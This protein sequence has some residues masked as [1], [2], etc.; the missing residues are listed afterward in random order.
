MDQNLDAQAET[1]MN[2]ESTNSKGRLYI[3]AFIVVFILCDV[4]LK[5]MAIIG[6]TL[7]TKAIIRSGIILVT[8]YFLWRGSRIAYW[9]MILSLLYLLAVVVSGLLG[10]IRID[11]LFF[12][13]FTLMLFA[14]LLAPSSRSFLRDKRTKKHNQQLHRTP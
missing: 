8:L 13:S 9:F 6:D 4:L 12:L 14:A 5:A 7:T 11:G 3:L 10:G 1:A 2:Q